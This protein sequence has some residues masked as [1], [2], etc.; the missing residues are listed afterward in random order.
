MYAYA[1][2]LI[3]VWTSTI[4]TLFL[5]KKYSLTLNVRRQY[6]KHALVKMGGMYSL[7]LLQLRV[8][9]STIELIFFY[10]PQDI[11]SLFTLN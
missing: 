5:D 9:Y 2:Y 6:V 10:V 8:N 1:T 4:C 3:K 11:F 7:V